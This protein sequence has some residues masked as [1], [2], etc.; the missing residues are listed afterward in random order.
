MRIILVAMALAIASPA[1]AQSDDGI[2]S[3]ATG[4][5]VRGSIKNGNIAKVS[6]TGQSNA[7]SEVASLLALYKIA[8]LAKTSG[9]TRFAVVK[10][11]CGTATMSGV[12]LY[13]Q[14]KAEAELLRAI[15]SD[16]AVK[17][18]GANPVTY[19]D[20]ESTIHRIES[21]AYKLRRY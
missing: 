9:F 14:C 7:R 11:S 4:G 1:N 12:T 17:T 15:D 2:L 18:K 10:Q 21:S 8:L 20:V 19:F 13:H 5:N 3:S 6:S 16:D